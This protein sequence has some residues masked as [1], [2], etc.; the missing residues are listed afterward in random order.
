MLKKIVKYLYSAYLYHFG[1]KKRITYLK[2]NKAII[3][4]FDHNPLPSN[5]EKHISWLIKKGF[6][7]ISLYELTDYL[8]GKIELRKSKIWFTLDDGWCGNLKLLPIIEKY[9]I[10]VTLF[11]P[12]YAIETGFFRDTL[13]QEFI[14]DLPFEYQKLLEIS[15]KERTVID[16]PLYERA[17]GVLPREVIN[18]EELNMLSEHPLISIGLHTHTHPVLPQCNEEEIETEIHNNRA[19][20]KEYTGI[21]PTVLALPYGRY[22]NNTLQSLTNNQITYVASSENGLIKP[23]K[24]HQIL[25]RNGIAKASFYENCCRILD[26][27]YP[28]INACQ[29]K[30]YD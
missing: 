4:I 6:E 27:W 16:E 15:N 26:F 13:E 12:T 21:D 9:Q 5:F 24:A 1:I 19:K 22:D 28:N 2:E 30:L 23:G 3:P 14:S 8:D 11:I 18:M 17:K 29:F 20:L 25:P 10:P 7:F